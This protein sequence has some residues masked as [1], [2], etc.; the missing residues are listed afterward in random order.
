[1][2]ETDRQGERGGSEI[3][4]STDGDKYLS[5]SIYCSHVPPGLK[6]VYFKT[7]GLYLR[8]KRLLPLELEK[9]VERE[10]GG[11]GIERQT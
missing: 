6:R 2:I 10:L 11:G 4:G 9:E 3:R 8:V 1:M 7:N 5:M